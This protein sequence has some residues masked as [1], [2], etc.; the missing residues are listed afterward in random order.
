MRTTTVTGTDFIGKYSLKHAS[1]ST[2]NRLRVSLVGFSELTFGSEWLHT[3][4]YW[5]VGY[6]SRD[7]KDDLNSICSI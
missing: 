5:N 3:S 7:T 6:C 4:C 1:D 2:E